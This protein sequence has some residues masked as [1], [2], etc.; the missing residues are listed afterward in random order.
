VTS[1]AVILSP[2]LDDAVLSCWSIL[3][4]VAPV[5]VINVF[6]GLPPACH[7]LA[8]GDRFTGAESSHERALERVH[9][10]AAVLGAL[11][12][13]RVNLE[14]LANQYRGSEQDVK[15]VVDAIL[16][17]I[18]RPDVIYAPAGIGGHPDHL[19]TRAAAIALMHR[20]STVTLYAD[21]PYCVEYGWPHWVSGADP[22]PYL[23]PTLL[24][25]EPLLLAEVSV[26]A[27]D[28]VVRALSAADQEEKL[29]ALLGYRTQF[30]A[31]DRRPGGTLSGEGAL[32][33]EVF[34][35]LAMPSLT[36]WRTLRYEAVWR[37][38]ARR[39][40]GLERLSRKPGLRRLRP[41]AGGRLGRFL[42]FRATR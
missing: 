6:A 37:L 39:G 36:R 22:D 1:G 29:T 40:G 42:R 23:D 41:K 5:T 9:E 13:E 38:G 8:P 15:P 10:D 25:Q 19:L 17:A 4:E 34:W 14:F 27:R 16:Q 28:G 26:D 18:G 35:P 12:R 24:W 21:L 31:L 33:Y 2:H 11:R 32:A 3:T 20:G 7:P 30:S